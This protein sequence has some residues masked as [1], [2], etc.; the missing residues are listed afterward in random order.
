MS[1]PPK[2]QRCFPLGEQS[3]LK[4]RDV[5]LTLI[6]SQLCWKIHQNIWTGVPRRR[7]LIILGAVKYIYLG[8]CDLTGIQRWNGFYSW[9]VVKARW[10]SRL[11]PNRATKRCV[12]VIPRL[13]LNARWAWT[14]FYLQRLFKCWFSIRKKKFFFFFASNY[15]CILC[16]IVNCS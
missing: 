13:G 4:Q 9:Q 6:C 5:K 10:K 1:R 7:P 16:A 2:N 3:G 8:H 14:R 15:F 11:R 12:R